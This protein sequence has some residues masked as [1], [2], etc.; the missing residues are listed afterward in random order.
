[1]TLKTKASPCPVS[2]ANASL[3]SKLATKPTLKTDME[4]ITLLLQVIA[5]SLIAAAYFVLLDI[6]DDDDDE[7]GGI[8]QPCYVTNR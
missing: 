8:L 2:Y 4:L 6:N 5:Y 1:M 7:D 3:L